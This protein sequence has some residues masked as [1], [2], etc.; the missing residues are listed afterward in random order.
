[1]L[2]AFMCTYITMDR[3]MSPQ[4]AP[5]CGK[6]WTPIQYKNFWL[7]RVCLRNGIS[8]SSAVSTLQ[9]IHVPNK[10]TLRPHYVRHLQQYAA[11]I[12]CMQAMRSKNSNSE[13]LDRRKCQPSRYP[14]V[15]T[16]PPHIHRWNKRQLKIRFN[17]SCTAHLIRRK[18][19]KSINISINAFNKY[20]SSVGTWDNGTVPECRNVNLSSICLLYTSPSPRDS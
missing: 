3:C 17:G 15:A 14:P 1:M 20:F 9:L 18:N 10:Q 4:N 8:I 13:E 19:N 11:S 6:I 5:F 2:N 12:R 16:A 7:T